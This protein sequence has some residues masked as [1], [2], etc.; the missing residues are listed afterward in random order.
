MRNSRLVVHKTHEYTIMPFG[1]LKNIYL[2]N[3]CND[4]ST[5][6]D[7]LFFRVKYD[8]KRMHGLEFNTTF[9]NMSSI[10]WQSVLLV[11]KTGVLGENHISAAIHWQALSHIIIPHRYKSVCD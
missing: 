9:N 6:L 4:N 10:S 5:Y 11:E 7:L 3:N 8:A 1:R 2:L